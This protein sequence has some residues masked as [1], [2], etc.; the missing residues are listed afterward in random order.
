MSVDLRKRPWYERSAGYCVAVPAV[1][2]ALIVLHLIHVPREEVPEPIPAKVLMVFEEDPVPPP[3]PPPE[4]QQVVPTPPPDVAATRRDSNEDGEEILTPITQDQVPA[5]IVEELLPLDPVPPSEPVAIED[6]IPSTEE[7]AEL[8]TI[9]E[10]VQLQTSHLEASAHELKAFLIREEVKSAAKNFEYDSDGGISGAIRTL[11]TN[12]F[13]PE[14]EREVLDRFGITYDHRYTKPNAG[15]SF[16]NAAETDSG[17]F[18]NTE[19]EGYYDV[20]VLSPKA[21]NLMTRLEV[22]ALFDRGFEPARSRV[23]SIVF[24][25]VLDSEGGY[26]L[27]V[28][29]MEVERLP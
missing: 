10:R 16:L 9:R 24:G 26:S 27:G 17:R 20:F 28:V 18:T 14:I 29:D 4:P 15:R 12:G 7:A 25:I 11:R 1:S 19:A 6:W 8:R 21:L 3:P 5:A 22:Q 13:P 2:L 23:R